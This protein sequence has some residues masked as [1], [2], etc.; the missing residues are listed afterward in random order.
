MYLYTETI[1]TSVELTVWLSIISYGRAGPNT[2]MLIDI[3]FYCL[4]AV[5]Y[6][7]I[8]V[9]SCKLYDS[10]YMHTCYV[11]ITYVHTYL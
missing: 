10:M 4:Q 8:Y 11:R 3:V 7:A 2:W 6:M 5:P 9:P 1:V